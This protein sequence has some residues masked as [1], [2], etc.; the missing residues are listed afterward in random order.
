MAV[1][2]NLYIWNFQLV[3]SIFLQSDN[4]KYCVTVFLNRVYGKGEIPVNI[5]L[6]K[7]MST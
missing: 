5:F 2:L 7:K 4:T 6:K 3:A 1:A